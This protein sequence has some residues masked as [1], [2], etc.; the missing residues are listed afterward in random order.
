ML[1][2]AISGREQSQ[3]HNFLFN[4]LVGAHEYGRRNGQAQRLGG[5]GIQHQFELGRLLDRQVGGQ[6][7][8]E[9]LWTT[10]AA[11]CRHMAARSGP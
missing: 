9:N 5:L 3:Q 6:S 8:L 10:I 11:L 7:T 2:C 4:H 1:L